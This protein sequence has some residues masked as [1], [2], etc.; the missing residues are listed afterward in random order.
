MR[1]ARAKT[2]E[3]VVVVDA[4]RAAQVEIAIQQVDAGRVVDMAATA[5]TAVVVATAITAAA[6]TGT[7]GVVQEIQAAVPGNKFHVIRAPAS[8]PEFF[9]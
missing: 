5:T 8:L 7:A 9:I 1:L 4:A 6:A 3:A 2:A